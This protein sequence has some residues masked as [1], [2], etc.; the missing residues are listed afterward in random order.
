MKNTHKIYR[1]KAYI[2]AMRSTKV[3]G[4]LFADL[5]AQRAHFRK[6]AMEEIPSD[7]L[8]WS[9]VTRRAGMT[10]SRW[11]DIQRGKTPP[12]ADDL[13]AICHVLELHFG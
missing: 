1:L 5:N 2:D 11:A 9:E 12:T 8:N 3:D 7:L 6:K 10:R 13:A 4:N